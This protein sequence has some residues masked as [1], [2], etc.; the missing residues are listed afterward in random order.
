MQYN[1]TL[2]YFLRVG[3]IHDI[4]RASPIE[5]QKLRIQFGKND[6]V[7][8]THPFRGPPT[9]AWLAAGQII[10]AVDSKVC[11]GGGAIFLRPRHW[12]FFLILIRDPKEKIKLKTVL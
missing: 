10:S 5:N 4:R 12:L 2:W 8:H 1:L 11:V 3:S 6:H 7:P 9:T